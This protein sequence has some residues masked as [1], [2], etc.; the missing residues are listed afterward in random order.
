MGQ[1][2]APQSAQDNVCEE[3]TIV[4][5]RNSI[6]LH[7]HLFEDSNLEDWPLLHPTHPQPL[8]LNIWKITF[9]LFGFSSWARKSAAFDLNYMLPPAH[10]DSETSMNY[11]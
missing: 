7:D 5:T 2:G 9:T 3:K 6:E 10:V 11:L 4:S 1:T 8:F